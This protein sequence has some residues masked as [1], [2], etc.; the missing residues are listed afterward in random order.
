MKIKGTGKVMGITQMVGP[1][2]GILNIESDGQFSEHNMWDYWCYYERKCL[3]I[4]ISFIN[5]LY[6]FISQKNLVKKRL[7]NK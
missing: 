3:K 7:K 4:Q 5:Y 6:I 2:S 1:Y